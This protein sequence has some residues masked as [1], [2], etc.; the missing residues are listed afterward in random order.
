MEHGR[1]VRNGILTCIFSSVAMLS[2]AIAPGADMSA[3]IIH[4]K[5][6]ARYS[7][8]NNVWQPA[9]VG[10]YLPAGSVIQTSTDNSFVDVALT[11][12][13]VGVSPNPVAF[14]PFIPSSQATTYT[15]M[16]ADNVLRIWENT[17]LGIDK[18]TMEDTGNGS[19]TET[20][21]DLK[22]G[23]VS[24]VAKK[25][26]AASKYEIK[27]PNGVASVR[28]TV[29]ELQAVGVVKVFNGSVMMAWVPQPGAN[30]VTQ[31]V[32]SGQK[33]DART[34]EIKPLAPDETAG[35]DRLV[36]D[37][38]AFEAM[39]PTGIASDMTFNSL[40]PVAGEAP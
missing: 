23:R 12:T 35:L 15:P 39:A 6:S 18:M 13:S 5:G 30:V 9:T 16:A 24:G 29:F 8:G 38:V 11:V 32:V 31:L 4:V 33:Y 14:K 37:L 2:I 34:G 19:V 36:A 17:A 1:V 28:G 22:Q 3:K 20:L 25:I 7:T 10:T 40:S 27:L 21:L 26:S